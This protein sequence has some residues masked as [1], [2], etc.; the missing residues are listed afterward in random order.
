MTRLLVEGVSL[1]VDP[2]GLAPELLEERATFVTLT[3]GGELRGCVGQVMSH[4]PLYRSVMDNACGA[5]LRDP[6]FAP[7]KR[8]ELPNLRIE[9]SVLSALLPLSFTSPEDLL[10]LAQQVLR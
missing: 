2:A 1:D 4:S 9:I 8:E 5:A 10:E 6:R 7:V 3:S